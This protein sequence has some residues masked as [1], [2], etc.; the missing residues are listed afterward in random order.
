MTPR[1]A[2]VSIQRLREA[3]QYNPD[4]GELFRKGKRAGSPCRD[5]YI[6]VSFD[7]VQFMAHRI[8][9]AVY[10][11]AFPSD[12]IDHINRIRSDNRLVNLR[13]CS[14]RDNSANK[15]RAVALVGTTYLPQY[16]KWQAQAKL[17]GRNCYLGVFDTQQE[18]RNAYL[19][20]ISR[21]EGAAAKTGGA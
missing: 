7:N 19:S 11:G 8:G 1:E 13:E 6:Q 15:G 3:I 20:A 2:R 12:Q 16:R 17:G 14:N 10:F 4:T 9:W 5:G 21:A 18:A